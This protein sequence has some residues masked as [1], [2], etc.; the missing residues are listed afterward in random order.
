M[1]RSPHSSTVRLPGPVAHW[2]GAMSVRVGAPAHRVLR[3]LLD[4]Y[5]QQLPTR[6][7]QQLRE[8]GQP[9][10]GRQRPH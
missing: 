7:R 10:S 4:Q 9:R 5:A 2:L 8:D 3:V 1:S 6:L